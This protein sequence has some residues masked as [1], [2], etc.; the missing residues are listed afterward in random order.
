[1]ENNQ[2]K[3][4]NEG[5]VSALKGSRL[6]GV[7]LFFI[8][9]I[10]DQVTKI[11]ADAYFSQPNA[12]DKIAVIP[13]WIY[14]CITYNKGISYGMGA[15]APAML[16]MA[17]IVGTAVLMSLFAMYYFQVDKR[18]T[19]LRIAIVFVVAGGVGNLIDRIYF[20]VWD[21][22]AAYGVRDMVDLNRFGFAVCNFADFFISAGAVMLV[23]SL[24]FF[25]KDAIFPLT[26]KYKTLAQEA[27]DEEER[28]K[29]EKAEKKAKEAQGEQ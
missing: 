27:A 20:E 11:V 9:I 28:K 18:R 7:L 24:L 22:N 17:V 3:K 29:A 13:D 8:L 2:M 1:M 6:W 23:L 14:L 10:V 15:N 5:G 12:P 26:K 25:D 19:L 21:P 4:Q 16:K